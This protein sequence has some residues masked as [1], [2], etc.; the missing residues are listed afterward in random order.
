MSVSDL[1]QSYEKGTLLESQAHASPFEQFRLWFDE[2]LAAKVPDNAMTLSTVDADGWPSS[3]IVLVKGYDDQGYTFFTNY[4]SRKGEE[5]AAN[6]RIAAVLLAAD[7]APGAHRG[8]RAE[9]RRR[10]I[11]PLQRL[12]LPPLLPPPQ[13]L[14]PPGSASALWASGTEPPG[15]RA[16]R[17]KGARAAN[18]CERY[19]DEPPRPPHWASGYRLAPTAFEFWQGRPS[20]LHD[21]LRY[22]PDGK[23][24]LADGPP[25]LPD[26]P[27]TTT[28][29]PPPARH[30]LMSLAPPPHVRRRLFPHRAGPLRHR[31]HGGHRRSPDGTPIGLTVS[32]F[33]S[34]SL[35]PPL[36]LW[37]L[38]LASSSLA[39]I[40]ECERYVV[41][42][43]SAGAD[44][45]GAALRHGQG[46]RALR[47][48]DPGA[49]PG[50]T[51]MIDGPCAAWFECRNR[52][53]YSEGDHLILVGE[54]EHCGPAPR[55]RWS[56]T[57]AAST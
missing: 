9:G 15:H 39:A 32:S 54:V 48:H 34:V 8:L 55:R 51:P 4:L 31:R 53:R 17:W 40:R 43:L 22:L 52:S 6:P 12:S 28:H 46:A 10:R 26:R 5:L 45:A 14:S 29:R 21:R 24:G 13:P 11:R 35:N 19:G 56:S 23:G 16:R 50:G 20:R 36:I 44:R 42:V 27:H 3:R 49:P 7:G 2:A 57:R 25:G 38:S 37:S 33:N 1:R 30:R 41:N 47:R 18:T